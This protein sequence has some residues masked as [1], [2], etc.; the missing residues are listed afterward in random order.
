[1]IRI[2]SEPTECKLQKKMTDSKE[3]L[4]NSLTLPTRVNT[5]ISISRAE[6]S[7]GEYVVFCL[8]FSRHG[9]AV[10]LTLQPLVVQY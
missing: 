6:V 4:R 7:F 1:M 3:Q 2:T 8:W 9:C 10:V 5:V